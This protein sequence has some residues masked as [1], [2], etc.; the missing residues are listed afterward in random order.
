MPARPGLE[1]DSCKRFQES[2]VPAAGAVKTGASARRCTRL[3]ISNIAGMVGR[4]AAA[5]PLVF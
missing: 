5:D 3:N 2:C 4:K 1:P